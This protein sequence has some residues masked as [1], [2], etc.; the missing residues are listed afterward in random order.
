MF[1]KINILNT[2]LDEIDT[3]FV[4]LKMIFENRTLP[5]DFT[6][7]YVNVPFEVITG[8]SIHEF[9]GMNYSVINANLKFLGFDWL[10]E[11][12]SLSVDQKL[13]NREIYL[14]QRQLHF[15]I[16][17]FIPQPGFLVIIVSDI[18]S[19]RIGEKNLQINDLKYKSLL[20]NCNDGFLFL[21]PDKLVT[22]ACTNIPLILGYTEEELK[23]L[24]DLDFLRNEDRQKV[25]DAIHQVLIHPRI[26]VELE[27]QVF[28]KDGTQ[29]WFEG[30]LH[31]MLQAKGLNSI[32][33]KLKEITRRK[34]EEI[35]FY[36]IASS[37]LSNY[38][39]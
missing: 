34:N 36:H 8:E 13:R 10:E 4:I 25:R 14:E 22:S 2:I 28:H 27:L 29:L 38:T 23:L 5:N 1:G 3:G 15:R 16:R 18:T 17:S 39:I 19:V 21:S 24:P 33:L 7:T 32:V 12:V 31:N 26:A 35:E 11:Y 20:E 30:T 9:V 37:L 6:I